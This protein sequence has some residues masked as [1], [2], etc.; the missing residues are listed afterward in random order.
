METQSQQRFADAV[1]EG[2]GVKGIGLVGAVHETMKRGYTFKNVAGTSAGA[3]VAALVAAGY[4]GNELRDISMD[5]DYSK[6]KQFDFIDHLPLLGP[7]VSLVFEKGL[8]EATYI[9]DRLRDLLAAKQ[10]HSFRDFVADDEMPGSKYY[11]RLQVI[12][13]DCTLGKMLV[14]PQDIARY[15]LNPDDLDVAFAV[16]MSANIPVYYEPVILQDFVRRRKSYIVDGGL[17]SN[18]PVQL[19]DDGTSLPPWPTFG[20][21]LV[22]PKASPEHNIG[23]PVS[24]LMA[25][26]ST[27][28][29]AHDARYIENCNFVRTIAID[30]LDIATTEFDI[31]HERSEA[32]YQSGVDAARKFFETWDFDAYKAQYRQA[33]PASRSELLQSQLVPVH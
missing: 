9:E 33:T 7:L 15:G 13:T 14:L 12:A 6:F 4:T 10:I 1:F 24:M 16:R 20:Y 19:F 27:M 22:D 31:T 28:M 17:L 3:I 23:G 18:F 32:L 29:D 25:L 8:Y 5:L 21:K 30:T 2:G 11:Y 26:V